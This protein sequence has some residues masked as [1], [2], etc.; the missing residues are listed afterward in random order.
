M[1]KIPNIQDSFV[2]LYIKKQL[3]TLGPNNLKR[4][5]KKSEY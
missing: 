3:T 4:I 2:K 5:K 1:Y